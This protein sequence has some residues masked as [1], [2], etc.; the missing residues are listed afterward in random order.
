MSEQDEKYLAANF[1]GKTIAQARTWQR[2]DAVGIEFHF[3][4]G[5]Y[6][7]WRVALSRDGTNQGDALGVSNSGYVLP[8]EWLNDGGYPNL[9]DTTG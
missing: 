2:G 5:T 4:D 8:R 7:G 9:V 6:A 1:I 3:T